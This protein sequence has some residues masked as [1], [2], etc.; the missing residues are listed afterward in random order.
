MEPVKKKQE[1]L[2]DD[3]SG[4]KEGTEHVLIENASAPSGTNGGLPAQG[5]QLFK[6]NDKYYLLQN[7]LRGAMRE[8][9]G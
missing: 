2:K 7:L 3:L 1:K 9:R 8:R 5:S 4:V 6:V